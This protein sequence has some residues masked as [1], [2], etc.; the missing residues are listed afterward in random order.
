MD[1][2]KL[3]FF[4]SSLSIL[5]SVCSCDNKERQE[6]LSNT[7]H[8]TIANFF[9]SPQDSTGKYNLI[10]KIRIQN[11]TQDT[12]FLPERKA[13]T[14]H[15]IPVIYKSFV[16]G[17]ILNKSTSFLVPIFI[18]G[19]TYVPPQWDLRFFLFC[20]NFFI[21]GS[22]GIKVDSLKHMKFTFNK[23]LPV[24]KRLLKKVIF[25]RADTASVMILPAGQNFF[26]SYKELRT[27][28]FVWPD[29]TPINY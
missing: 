13:I 15:G 25:Q 12:I 26:T 20:D 5:L 29:G 2:R 28:R 27:P 19:F 21:E 17:R 9:I 1:M 3:M 16:E 23:K 10:V 7:L 22:R 8:C 18:R 11:L 24:G 14:F 6:D 4:I